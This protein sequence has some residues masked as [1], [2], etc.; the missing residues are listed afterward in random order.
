MLDGEQNALKAVSVLPGPWGS[1]VSVIPFPLAFPQRIR[2]AFGPDWRGMFQLQP[3]GGA[4][5]GIVARLI[6]PVPGEP[7]VLSPH[8][9]C[10][11]GILEIIV[12]EDIPDGTRATLEVMQR[13]VGAPD[14]PLYRLPQTVIVV[15]DRSGPTIS[16]LSVT[17]HVGSRTITISI[18]AEDLVS[19]VDRARV[20]YCIEGEEHWAEAAMTAP[21]DW[22]LED[23]DIFQAVIGPFCAGQTVRL[24]A[25]CFD[26]VGNVTSTAEQ[27][28]EF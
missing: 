21:S 26:T 8:D 12:T 24:Q 17:P 19:G 22:E 10:Y 2:N 5:P 13:V 1:V 27:S 3:V 20:Q 9:R 28:V 15:A 6:R 23:P 14:E 7:Y 11:P 18:E 4:P 16:N 25:I